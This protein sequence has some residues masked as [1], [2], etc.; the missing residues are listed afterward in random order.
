MFSWLFKKK[1]TLEKLQEEHKILLS[2]AHKSATTNRSLSDSYMLKA[3]EIDKKI[4]AITKQ[5]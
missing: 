5:S 4:E 3:S 2:K 1:S